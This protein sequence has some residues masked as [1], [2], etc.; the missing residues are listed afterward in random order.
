MI[1]VKSIIVIGVMLLVGWSLPAQNSLAAFTIQDNLVVGI[2]G[3][4]EIRY[5]TR[6]F[7]DLKPSWSP[8]GK[9]LVKPLVR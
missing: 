2:P 8:D 3:S 1:S 9:W 6:G 7:T 5:L 4:P